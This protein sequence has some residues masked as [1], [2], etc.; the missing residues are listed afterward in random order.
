MGQQSVS[1][2]EE[3]LTTLREEV[4]RAEELQAIDDPPEKPYSSK[5]KAREI[6][7][8][9]LDKVRTL[10]VISKQEITVHLLVEL[11]SVDRKVEE[12]VDSQKNLGEAVE[13]AKGREAEPEFVWAMLKA[14]NQVWCSHITSSL[15]E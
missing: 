6:L 10:D 3:V 13:A 1:D 8:S 2:L 11:G 7:K 9:V 12:L 15:V 14:L 4:D 5:Y